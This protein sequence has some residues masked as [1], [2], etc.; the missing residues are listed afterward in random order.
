MS[1]EVMEIITD[2]DM[3]SLVDYSLTTFNTPLLSTFV[4]RWHMEISSFHLSF[5]EITI[6]LD[7]VSNLLH[8]SVAGNLFTDSVINQKIAPM[9]DES[10]LGLHR[11]W[12]WR[13]SGL[14]RVLI[15]AFLGCRIPIIHR[16]NTLCIGR[17]LGYTCF[18]L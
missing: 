9:A 6:S 1:Y 4:K 5:G 17:K 11:G 14:T 7:N 10:Y 12:S 15:F 13:S 2:D 8:L 16:C 3:L 18:I